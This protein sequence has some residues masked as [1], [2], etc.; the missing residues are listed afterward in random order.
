MAWALEFMQAQPDWWGPVVQDRV[1]QLES[2]HAR[3]RPLLKAAKL[4]VQPHTPPDIVGCYVLIPA[5]E[6][7]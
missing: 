6:N 1:Q 3:L 7:R 2:A 4:T 5:G